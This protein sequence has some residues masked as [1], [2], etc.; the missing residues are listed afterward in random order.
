MKLFVLFMLPG[1]TLAIASLIAVA[2]VPGAVDAKTITEIIDSTGDGGGNTLSFP[3]GVAVDGSGNVYVTGISSHNAFQI[4]PNGT[5]A[6]IIDSTG[7]GGGNT[8][9]DP[10]AVAVDGSGNVYVTGFYSDNAFQIDPNGTIT[11]IIDSTGDGGGNTLSFPSG[12]AVDGSGNV[13]VTGEFSHNAFKIEPNGV[14]TEIIDSTGDGSGNTLSGPSG[15][16]VDGLGNVYVTGEFSDNAFRIEPGGTITQIIDATGDG[17][18]NTLASASDVAVDGSGNVYV[19][20]FRSAFKIT[21]GGAITEIFRWS[22][23]TRGGGLDDIAA[24]DSG[25]VYVAESGAAGDSYCCPRVFKIDP[26]G[27][28][29]EIIDSTG[30]GSGNTLSGPSGVAVDGLGNVYVTGGGSDNAF[31]IEWVGEIPHTCQL[32]PNSQITWLMTMLGPIVFSLTSGSLEIN[33]DAVDPHTGKT[34]CDCNL[35]Q[36]GAINI[37]G[38]GWLCVTPV[39]GCPMG[40]LDCAGGNALDWALVSNHNIG[41]CTGHG[42]CVNQCTTYCAGLTPSKQVHASGCEGFCVGGSN[43][44]AACSFD[45]QC[46]YGSCLGPEPSDPNNPSP[47]HGNICQCQ[48]LG[49]GGSPGASGALSCK[50]GQLIDVESELPCDGAD[51]IIPGVPRCTPFTTETMT[52]VL[53]NVNNNP[54][55]LIGPIVQTGQSAVC[56]DLVPRFG[57][58]LTLVGGDGFLDSDI[59]DMASSTRFICTEALCGDGFLDLGEECDD[60]NTD[61]CDGCSGTCQSEG[62]CGDGILDPVCEQCDDGNNIDGDGCSSICINGSCGDGL[63]QVSRGEECDDGNTENCD[64]CSVSCVIDSLSGNTDGDTLCDDEDPCK[65]YA[66]TLPLVISGF[67]GIPDE[68]LCGDFDGDGFHS[69]TDAAAINDCAA[70]IRFDCVSERDEVTGQCA[71]G[72]CINDG[73]YSAMD[74]ELVNRV[75]AFLD[76]AYALT[77]GRRPEGTCGGGT[78][79]SCFWA[80]LIA[81]DDDLDFV[82]HDAGSVLELPGDEGILANDV[83]RPGSSAEVMR[84]SNVRRGTLQLDADGTIYFEPGQDRMGN[85]LSDSFTYKLNDGVLVSNVATVRINVT[86]TNADPVA[87]DDTF[88]GVIN[89]ALYVDAPGILANDWDDDGD[90]L[91]S[92]FHLGS[93]GVQ[94]GS[95]YLYRHGRFSYFPDDGFVGTD[96]FEYMACDE[97]SCSNVATV[98]IVIEPGGP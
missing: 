26:N 94:N 30:D 31:R 42:D 72:V 75:A 88:Y 22:G 36:V 1:L 29:T 60:G 18:G 83:I 46:P 16:A 27:T 55:G 96:S 2:V 19:I 89:T 69:A 91:H 70:F 86:R 81:N 20:G 76:P 54:N 25:N 78:G 63:T 82:F 12:V 51:V 97:M 39:G 47:R 61:A 56:T 40:E 23:P 92:N 98:T 68:C 77:C 74:A 62:I 28:I 41:S 32:D 73:F 84:V 64:G 45:S 15:V 57:F 3:S 14:I 11:E 65:H 49:S 35:G 8:L 95:L 93:D 10:S 24:D 58:G 7:D 33:C 66:N 21:P 80:S 38:I 4:D 50:I 17:A 37:T 9:N 44:G 90:P 5:I 6:E 87:M 34:S 48:C 52:S 13:Y 67:S 59:G 71:G 53:L 79:V 43:D 85:Y